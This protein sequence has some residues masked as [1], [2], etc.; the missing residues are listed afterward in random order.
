M[1]RELNVVIFEPDYQLG[2]NL[3]VILKNNNFK[4]K[5]MLAE[6]VYNNYSTL[7]A[8]DVLIIDSEIDNEI[9]N[10]IIEETKIRIPHAII[11]A[12]TSPKDYQEFLQNTL[13]NFDFLLNKPF[14]FLELKQIIRQILMIK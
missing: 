12:V 3:E 10:Y 11:V 14:N 7:E 1:E 4:A 6:H 8:F 2:L 9:F 5:Q 13:L